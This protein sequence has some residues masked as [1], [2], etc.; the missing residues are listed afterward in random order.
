MVAPTY[1]SIVSLLTYSMTAMQHDSGTDKGILYLP[2]HTTRHPQY[3][4]VEH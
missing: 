4:G 3:W 2:L 1:H